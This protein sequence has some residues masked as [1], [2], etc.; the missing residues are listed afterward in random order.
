MNNHIRPEDWRHV[1]YQRIGVD[2][3]EVM[4]I[5]YIGSQAA[6]H[7]TLAA[8]N[9]DMTFEQGATTA[10]AAVGTGD[11]PGTAGVINISD[12]ST[13]HDVILEIN[14]AADWEAWHVDFIPDND[15]EVTAGN[16]IY[17]TT[18]ADQDCTPTNGFAVLVDT[19]LETAEYFP[20]GVTFNGPNTDPHGTDSNVLH[21]I[22]QIDALATFAG[23]TD[24]IYIYAC[25]DKAGTS[26]QIGH[27][28]LV[29]A[30]L[31]SF[32]LNGEP[33]FSNS[34]YP[35]SRLVVQT[36]DASG[37]ITSPDIR[38]AAQSLAFGPA[39]RVDKMW[40]EKCN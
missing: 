12:Y 10:A 15:I 6:A 32:E 36:V 17:L 4:R 11:N 7:V 26:E 23:A 21:H 16:A 35:G 34:A 5:H 13:I 28:A 2:T 25:N 40:A 37:A 38:V 14:S 22:V 20:V 27:L 39:T 9:G 30:T 19:S 1:S 18:L 3:P 24:G 31:T 8:T 33:L 29:S